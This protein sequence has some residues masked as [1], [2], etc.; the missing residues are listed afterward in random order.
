MGAQR[1]FK[2]VFLIF[3]LISSV[4]PASAATGK[5]STATAKKSSAVQ[6]STA[7]RNKSSA[8][9][10]TSA[11]KTSGKSQRIATKKKSSDRKNKDV[12]SRPVKVTGNWQDRIGAL[13]KRGGVYVESENGQELFSLNSDTPFIPASTTKVATASA[14]LDLLGR[15]YR[16]PTDFFVDKERH[17][18]IKGYGD[19]SLVSEELIGIA[20]VLKNKGVTQVAGIYLDDTYFSPGITIPGSSRSSNPYD[21]HNGAL[22]I[23]YNT[24]SVR[25]FKGGRVESDE[26][27]TPTTPLMQ[28]MAKNAPIG[29]S[30]ISLVNYPRESLLYVGELMKA[31][32]EQN[33]VMVTGEIDARPTPRTATLLYRNE[34]KK[35][36]SE[37]LHELLKYS[38]NFMANQVYLHMGARLSAPPANLDK[39]NKIMREYLLKK[40]GLNMMCYE[41]SGLC[42]ENAVSSRDM[43]KLLKHFA[44]YYELLK[45]RDGAWVK[46]GT[47]NGVSCLT[48]YLP[49]ARYGLLRFVIM[50][51][52]P[53]NDRYHVY[54]AIKEGLSS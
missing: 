7:S 39:S 20:Q 10:K 19:P 2:G 4:L 42:R 36:L 48:G 44:P 41:G 33:G 47:L 37:I 9:K 46:T 49:T 17:L 1:I 38:N 12:R 26:A 11:K 6:K 3:F 50:L 43:A 16:F 34:S 13:V 15:D 35:P 27:Q 14:A 54:D 21:A 23:N 51:N 25:K 30:R 5:K 31:F 32:L 8:R 28:M 52:Q 24:I 22:F 29:S 18:F 53:G 40:V 45:I